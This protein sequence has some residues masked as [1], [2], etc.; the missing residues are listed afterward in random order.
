MNSGP[1][2]PDGECGLVPRPNKRP[3]TRFEGGPFGFDGGGSGQP[4]SGGATVIRT[5][6]PELPGK[7]VNIACTRF[8][9]IAVRSLSRDCACARPSNKRSEEHTSEL[10]SLMRIS[11]AG[12]C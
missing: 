6:S 5:R 1:F 3:A 10:Q 11:Y 9:T 12:F 7:P 8:G 4:F 2:S